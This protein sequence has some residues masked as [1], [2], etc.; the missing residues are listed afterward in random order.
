MI[1]INV[2]FKNFH[3]LTIKIKLECELNFFYTSIKSYAILKLEK[4][5]LYTFKHK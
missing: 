3:E 5:M 4:Y 1:N 2:K